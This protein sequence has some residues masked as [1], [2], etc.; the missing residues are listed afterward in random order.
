MAEGEI[1]IPARRR[2]RRWPWVVL[3]LVI[4]GFLLRGP[5]LAP[6]VTRVAAAQLA[7]GIHGEA[8]VAEASGGWLSDLQLS[9]IVAAAPLGVVPQLKI[10]SL[11]ASYGPGIVS[12]DLTAVRSLHLEGVDAVIDLRRQKDD[13]AGMVPPLL[14]LLPTPL[15]E[16]SLRGEVLLRLPRS[17]VRLSAL[18]VTVAA[19]SLALEVMVQ[20]DDAAPVRVVAAFTRPSADTLQLDRAVVI[21]DATLETM[22]LVLGRSRRELTAVLRLGGGRLDLRADPVRVDVTASGLDLAAVPGAV[23]ALV[24]VELG[25]VTGALA[26][27]LTA[28]R[29]TREWNLAGALRV[30]GFTAAGVGPFTLTAQGHLGA[31]SVQVPQISLTGPGGGRL[32]VSAV[33]VALP[34]GLPITGVLH[35]E[36]PD[37]RS[38]LPA[39]VP[40]PDTPLA[41]R[42]DLAMD[43]EA[44]VITTAEL[45]GGGVQAHLRGSLV[46][47]PWRIEAADLKAQADLAVVAALFPQAPKLAGILHGRLGGTLPLSRDP[48]TLLRGIL[49]T[50]LH[51]EALTIQDTAVT[52]L[53]ID[54]RTS[55]GA[56][57]ID[58]VEATSAGIT[59]GL[60]GKAALRDQGLD[61]SVERLVVTTPRA[62]VNATA[63]FP[64]RLAA[65]RWSVGPVRLQSEAGD[66]LLELR[67]ADGAGLL[68]LE[69]PTVDLARLGL[70]EVSGVA[71]ISIDLSGAW[72]HPIA[73]VRMQTSEVVV[74]GR[75]AQVAIDLTQD[76]TGITI[77]SGT[78]DAG[79]DGQLV[80]SGT[81]PF[82]VGAG[83]IVAVPDDGKPAA[84]M[85]SVPT[86][87]R[88]WPRVIAAGGAGLQLEFGR[89]EDASAITGAMTFQGLRPLVARGHP[90]LQAAATVALDG[91]I[92]IQGD[93]AGVDLTVA[94]QAGGR[95]VVAGDA[96]SPGAW[97]PA[98]ETWGQR[99]L[100]GTLTMSGLDLGPFA[101]AI[102]RVL[103]L[104]GRAEG[105]LTL[106]GT[107]GEPALDGTL[108]LTGV[109]AKV[110]SAVP[111]ISAGTAHF[112]LAGRT[113][114]LLDGVIELGGAPV[115]AA[116]VLSLDAPRRLDLR[117]DGTNALLVQ[118]HDA[119]V[120]A[121]FALSLTGALDALTLGGTA[122]V[123]NA[124]FSPDLNLWGGDGA[125]AIDGRLVPF[126]FIDPPLSDLRFDVKVSSAFNDHSDGVHLATDLVRAECDLDLHLGGSGAAP[127]LAGRVTVRQGRIFLPFSTL[128]MTTGEII[129]PQGD[130]FH[131]RLNA[132]AQAQVRRYAVTLQ[133]DGPLADPQVRASGDGLDQ[134]DALLL[135]TTGSTN[136]ELTDAQGQ[137]AAL[138]RLG[139]WLGMEAWD[140]V[141]GRDD[142]DAGPGLM[143]RVTL[144]LGRQVSDS[145]KDTIEAQVE[146]T[147]PDER[148]AVLIFGERDRWDDYNAGII[149]RFRWA[150]EE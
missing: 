92:G 124:L 45:S 101:S 63:P 15:P 126:E 130:P 89:L 104:A 133:V 22:Q 55:E 12:G 66:A 57:L 111:T 139:T 21:G 47:G 142:P 121:N 72:A 80:M 79:A 3:A 118:R 26:G 97:N 96:H 120:R 103:H 88:W 8:S 33:S 17:D 64:L 24:P 25:V 37:L 44:L 50:Q 69:A 114:R 144:D 86:L 56:L 131:P 11:R 148:P 23:L 54:A 81:L 59:V 60:G 1:R 43:G 107:I 28:I 30:T 129:F 16:A 10:A 149:L 41:L 108:T 137:R 78:V 127:E 106:A 110:A 29:A 52:K 141:D 93:R 20:V 128:R 85:I 98:P 13:G 91:T 7:K 75:R 32:S 95:P 58:Q 31:G 74:A 40:L 48:A 123:T 35:A 94:L 2:R 71:G 49:T 51:S 27:E 76:H 109:E 122:V 136:A 100:R 5:L 125:A 65:Q 84:V 102:P 70:A 6:L 113:L 77:R 9:G 39:I 138:S 38:W 62:V 134:R 19:R 61:A 34:H 53:R 105:A 18:Q 87:T 119:R 116:G 115:T 132:V 117:L 135:L 14:E 140:L 82:T 99:P 147:K 67:H 4:V 143:E 90:T 68:H 73:Q 36:I 150:G 112:T 42:A 146:L 83:G 46:A 145:G